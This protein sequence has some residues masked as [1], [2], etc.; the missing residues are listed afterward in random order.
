MMVMPFSACNLVCISQWD[1]GLRGLQK[2][3]LPS[4][5][6]QQGQSCHHLSFA[7]AEFPESVCER[8]RAEE[9]EEEE[10]LAWG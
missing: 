8:D 10:I 4:W 9:R 7:M 2:L 5:F 6:S 1:H 3:L